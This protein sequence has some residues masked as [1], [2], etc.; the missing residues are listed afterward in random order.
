MKRKLLMAAAV[1]S[2][3]AMPTLASADQGSWY[4][5]ANIGY[6]KLQSPK[7]TGALFW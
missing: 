5:R 1:G 2:F 7:V 6:G 4:A 3:L